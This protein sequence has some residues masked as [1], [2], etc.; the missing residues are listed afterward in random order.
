MTVHRAVGLVGEG[1][2]QRRAAHQRR[3]DEPG[4]HR[5]GEDAIF[6]G[7][8]HRIEDLIFVCVAAEQH[9]YLPRTDIGRGMTQRPAVVD[10]DVHAVQGDGLRELAG[11]GEEELQVIEVMSGGDGAGASAP[12]L[13]VESLSVGKL[14]STSCW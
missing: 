4:S 8:A 10:I 7:V 12:Q 9:D 3:G 11:P 2:C 13:L 1:H 5:L 14:H 6:P